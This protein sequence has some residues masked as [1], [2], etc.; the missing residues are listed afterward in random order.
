VVA[1]PPPTANL[2]V[3]A[4]NLIS[5]VAEIQKRTALEHQTSHLSLNDAVVADL[6]KYP[7]IEDL[8]VL[9]EEKATDWVQGK[10][11]DEETAT[12]TFLKAMRTGDLG[13]GIDKFMDQTYNKRP[14]D[15]RPMP[16]PG[17]T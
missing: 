13:S 3:S 9:T 2:E 17:T 1:D 7:A 4:A 10:D 16:A 12:R 14:A 8:S 6:A 15:L 11:M 5:G